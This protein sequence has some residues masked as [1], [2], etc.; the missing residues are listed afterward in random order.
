[1]SNGI[2]TRAGFEGTAT[3]PGGLVVDRRTRLLTESAPMV[4]TFLT[5]DTRETGGFSLVFTAP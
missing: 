2:L 5:A 4:W 1:V 3:V